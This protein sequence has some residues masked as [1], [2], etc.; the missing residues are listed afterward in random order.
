MKNINLAYKALKG[1]WQ[2]YK[3]YDLKKRG[4]NAGYIDTQ[5]LFKNE[6]LKHL[7]EMTFFY[8]ENYI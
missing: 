1:F 8:S 2:T 7:E 4:I 5:I 6:Y 3:L